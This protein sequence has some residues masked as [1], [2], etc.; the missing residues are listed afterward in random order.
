MLTIKLVFSAFEAQSSIVWSNAL[1]R[2]LAFE[3]FLAHYRCSCAQ[4]GRSSR[5]RIPTLGP[6]LVDSLWDYCLALG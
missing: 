3:W 2:R 6:Q 5:A 1:R 4:S